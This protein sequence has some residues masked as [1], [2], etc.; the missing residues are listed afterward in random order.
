MATL[1]NSAKNSTIVTGFLIT[2]V[3]F[4]LCSLSVSGLSTITSLQLSKEVLF[5]I[6]RI[7]IWISLG[8]VYLYVQNYE[9]QPLL[10]WN[11]KRYGFVFYLVSIVLLLLIIIAG[12]AFI[13]LI[14]H[15]LKLSGNSSKATSIVGYG[16]PLKLFIV[17][18]A[19]VTEELIF[20]GYLMPRIQLFLKNTWWPIIISA[21]V[22]GLVHVRYGTFINVIGPAFI[23]FVSA[24]HYQ[25]YQN[26]KVLMICHFLIDFFALFL[27]H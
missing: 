19:A 15:Q 1:T 5:L 9:H 10:L 17:F 24:W 27:Q 25:K 26:I 21:F 3:L 6:S 20:R 11:E 13:Q 4:I 22:F 12:S 16:A 14:V 8:L 2:T 23:G 7:L 18:T